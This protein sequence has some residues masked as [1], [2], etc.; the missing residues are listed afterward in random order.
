LPALTASVALSFGL[1]V[2]SYELIEK[3]FLQLQDRFTLKPALLRA[4]A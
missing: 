3:R 2:A 1:A 4:A